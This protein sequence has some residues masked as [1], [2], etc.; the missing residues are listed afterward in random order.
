MLV[1]NLDRLNQTANDLTPRV[2]VGVLQAVTN[3]LGEVI[4]FAQH[5]LKVRALSFAVTH[6]HRFVFQSCQSL[7]SVP[8]TRFE[9][10]LLQQTRLIRID[11]SADAAM[12]M[13]NLL[14]ELLR[15]NIGFRGSVKP[16]LK[17]GL[18]IGRVLQ[19]RADVAPDRGIEP[20]QA[21][22]L[23]PADFGPSMSNRISAGA[24]IVRVDR[25]ARGLRSVETKRALAVIGPSATTAFHQSLQQISGRLVEVSLLSL[26][27]FGQLF[28]HRGVQFLAHQR[29]YGNHALLCR[30][31]GVTRAG[32]ARLVRL[33]AKRPQPRTTLSNPRFSEDCRFFVGWISQQLADHLAVPTWISFGAADPLCQQPLAPHERRS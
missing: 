32:M 4:E 11:Q 5:L 30:V 9:F 27:L 15:L 21:N 24:A 12:H 23:A 6:F 2:P 28:R 31:A 33:P 7:F 17:L 1:V 13:G 16:T 19:D 22:G 18:Q 8:H 14:H 26:C 25:L 20:V 29:R 10:F 3:L